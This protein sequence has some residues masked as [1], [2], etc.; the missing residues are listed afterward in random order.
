M[1]RSLRGRKCSLTAFAGLAVVAALLAGCRV[2]TD[3]H[4]DGKDVKIETPFG[5]LQVKTNDADVLASLGLPGYPGA[6]PAKK[7]GDDD[8][9]ADVNI[10][11]GGLQMRV[12][13]AK[14]RTGDS[15]D[16]VE[17]FYRNGMR[18]YGDVIAC[19]NGNAV[20]SPVRTAEGLTCDSAHSNHISVDD[21]SKHELELKAG[22]KR[23]QHIVAIDSDGGGTKF[24]LVSLDLPGDFTG[25]K[26]SDDTRQ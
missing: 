2:E 10:G 11:F 4:G 13:A 24:S 5:G 1:T 12:K 16:K 19:R 17:A 8:G 21:D 6:Q 9:S 20:G 22:S 3:K 18:R 7:H 15:P 25:G 14:Y 23:Y 26:E